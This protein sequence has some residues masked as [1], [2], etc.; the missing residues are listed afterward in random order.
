MFEKAI[1]LDPRYA[2]AYAALSRTQLAEWIFWAPF[3]R[4]L[5]QIL[6]LAQR[7]VELDD[8]LP[9]PHSV[10]GNVYLW[11]KQH[12]QAIAAAERGLAL[13][14]NFAY[15]HVALADILTFAGRPEE[16]IGLIEKARRLDPAH[17]ADASLGHAYLLTGRY[18]EA[19]AAL[20][21]AL[22]RDPNLFVG[23]WFMALSYS[24]AGREEEAWATVREF[25]RR[26]PDVSLDGAKLRLPYRDPAIEARHLDLMQKA[27]MK[28][29]W[30]TDNAEA[31][32]SLWSGLESWSSRTQEGN[33]QARQ[34][35]ARALALD[36]QYAAAYALLGETYLRDWEQ[37]ESNDPQLLERA[38]DLT[39]KAMALDASTAWFHRLLSAVSLR[40]KQHDQALVEGERAVALDPNDADSYV[41]LAETLSFAGQPEKAIGLMEKARRLNPQYAGDWYVFVLGR[42]Y[43]RMGRYQEATAAFKR[44]LARNPD[45]LGVHLNLAAIY[46]GS[47]REE[48]ARAEAAEVLRINPNF[49]L[50]RLRPRLPFKD[51]A[52]L[53]RY[54]DA[55]RQAGLQ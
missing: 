2:A 48:E 27:G 25:L 10:L 49:S 21:R 34:R 52:A 53:D 33:A 9:L 29:R 3:Q 47:G 54:L 14:A 13:D 6:A 30:P 11:K 36:P 24:E 50:E 7:A 55:L 43:A 41:V 23:Y 8:A 15:G 16:A 37:Y 22:S 4:S 46:S 12:D 51:P 17:S 28:W 42:S 1:E 38:S 19:I 35:F 5:D 44:I 32:G 40:Q 31:F 45:H 26:Q 18:E 20:K 39:H